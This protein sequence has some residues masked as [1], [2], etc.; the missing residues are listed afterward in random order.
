MPNHIY[1]EIRLHC[2]DLGKVNPLVLNADGKISFR[3][4]LPLPL[5]FWP[6]SVSRAHEE[7]FPGTHLDAAMATWGTKWDAYGEPAISQDGADVLITLKTAWETPRGWTVALFNSLGCDITC[8]WMD[9]GQEAARRETY[10][11]CPQL[12]PKWDQTIIGT[13]TDDHRRLHKGLWGVES[14]PEEE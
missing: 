8:N 7:A 6:G 5:H 14:F 9:E 13:T 2:V 3:V 10:T 4:L 11:T 1:S 12:G